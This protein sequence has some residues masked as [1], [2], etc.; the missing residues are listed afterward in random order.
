MNLEGG[1]WARNFRTERRERLRERESRSHRYI[2]ILFG[3]SV[4]LIQSPHNHQPHTAPPSIQ[5]QNLN[6]ALSLSFH[7]KL[8]SL[9]FPSIS[10]TGF[11]HHPLRTRSP[12][13][14]VSS[15]QSDNYTM[16]DEYIISFLFFGVYI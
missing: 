9:S 5:N 6:T 12:I 7:L 11:Q 15:K 4:D 2:V 3:V 16:N 13:H 8:L 14:M 1:W 10:L